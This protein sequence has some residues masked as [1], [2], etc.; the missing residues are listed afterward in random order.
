[1]QQERGVTVILDEDGVIKDTLV[2]GDIAPSE[3]IPPV[4][5]RDQEMMEQNALVNG[6]DQG[7]SM[8]E[9]DREVNTSQE[10]ENQSCVCSEC[11]Y[12]SDERLWG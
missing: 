9:E 11:E 3:F 1:M 4:N 2:G 8:E 5:L 7:E 12:L 10:D 6:Q